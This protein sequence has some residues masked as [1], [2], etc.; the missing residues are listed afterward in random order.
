MQIAW[1][2][3]NLM[4][5]Q[6]WI[7]ESNLL[8]GRDLRDVSLDFLP[9]TDVSTH[10]WGC[11]LLHT[12]GGLWSEEKSALCINLLELWA[13]RLALLQFQNFL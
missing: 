13:V 6:W 7:L 5:L 8:A 12:A 1:T 4:D 10:G 9:Y 2:P 3:D 11:S